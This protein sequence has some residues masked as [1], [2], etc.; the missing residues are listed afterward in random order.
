MGRV[1][2]V[3]PDQLAA[4][5]PAPRRVRPIEVLEVIDDAPRQDPAPDQALQGDLV[6][7]PKPPTDGGK[8]QPGAASSPCR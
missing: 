3:D 4:L 2:Q 8:R 1:A 6:D 5:R 7:E